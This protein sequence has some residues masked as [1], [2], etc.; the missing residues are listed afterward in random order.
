MARDLIISGEAE[1]DLED[2]W[3]YV[4]ADSP[5]KADH[6]IVQLYQK[7]IDISDLDGIGR[8]RDELSAGLFSIPHKKYIIFFE[9]EKMHINIVR[10]LRGARDLD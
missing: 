1:S 8:R 7:C 6:F 9:R 5:I 4:A 10:I 3:D 2:I